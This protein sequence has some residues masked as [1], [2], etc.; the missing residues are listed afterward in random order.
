[1]SDNKERELEQFKYL[2]DSR[3]VSDHGRQKVSEDI[4]KARLERLKSR[5]SQEI[6]N[7][8]LLQLKLKMERFLEADYHELTGDGF[9]S[10]CIKD[11]ADILYT[12]R[13]DFA[14]DLNID[15]NVL[16]QVINGHRPPHKDMLFKLAIHSEKSFTPILP[17]KRSTWFDLFQKDNVYRML[18][19]EKHRFKAA[20]ENVKWQVE[21]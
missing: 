11:Y 20:E 10:D 21:E 5:S 8:Q 4:T 3:N 16:S 2:I 12:R 14:R 9:I 15:S 13:K 19:L 18:V 1:M 7:A 6:R 17:F